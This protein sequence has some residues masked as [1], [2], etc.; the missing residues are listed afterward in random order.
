MKKDITQET[1]A[2]AKAALGN[3]LSDDLIKAFTQ[4]GTATTGITAYD[5]QAPA[6]SLFPVLTPLRNAIPRVGGAGGIQANWKAILAINVGS[7]AVGV[8]EGNRGGVVATNTADYSASYRGIGLEDYVTFEAGYSAE[9]FQDVRALAQTNLLRALMIGEEQVILG[10]NS[11]MALGTTPTP[12]ATGATT[13]GALANGTYSVI[14]AALTPQGLASASITSGVRGAVSRTNADGSTDAYGGGTAKLSTA[15]SASVASGSAGSI[16]ASVA[17]VKGAA[18]YAWFWGASGSEVL[19]AITTINSVVITA[20]AAGT[21]T[22]ASLGTADNST[23]SLVFDGL[24]TQALK[25]GAGYYYAMPTGTAGTGTPL[26]ADGHGGIV[27]IDT[28][29]KSFW[30]NYRLSP[31][32]IWVSAQEQGNIGAKIA[33]GTSNGAQRFTI[34]VAD[35]GNMRAGTMVRSYLN[36]FAMGGAKEIPIEIHPNLPAG[37]ILFDTDELPYPLSGVSNVK[38]IRCRRDYYSQEWPQRS[39]KYEYGVYA[40]EVLQNFAPFAFGVISNIANG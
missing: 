26:T 7:I 9:G 16:A 18:G 23:N 5:L 39:R 35:Q 15:A 22:A 1:L 27:E 17:A 30:D 19:G 24:T 31:S 4:S 20:A 29:L 21:Q 25:T 33:T 32:T 37:T 40:D 3:P 10:G 6:L 12:T 14:C 38:Q 13:G 36:K 34:S 11:S 2:L 28:A 8:G